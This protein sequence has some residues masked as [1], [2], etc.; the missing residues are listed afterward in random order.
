MRQVLDM[1]P[2][3]AGFGA[4]I[5]GQRKG[6]GFSVEFRLYS[7]SALSWRGEGAGRMPAVPNL[8]FCFLSPK[9]DVTTPRTPPGAL[10]VSEVGHFVL[11]LPRR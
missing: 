3:P 4:I 8:G 7:G 11:G 6:P 10:I 2:Q 5:W 9:L 1:A